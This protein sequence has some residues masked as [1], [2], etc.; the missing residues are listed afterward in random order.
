MLDLSADITFVARSAVYR[1][2][3]SFTS[4]R[5]GGAPPNINHVIHYNVGDQSFTVSIRESQLTPYYQQTF[6]VDDINASES[7]DFET[8]YERDGDR[9]VLSRPDDPDLG[10]KYVAYAGWV[11]D[12]AIPIGTDTVLNNRGFSTFG[13]ETEFE[14]MPNAGQATYVLR[15]VGTLIDANG[16]LN[17]GGDGALTADFASGLIETTMTIETIENGVATAWDTV[18][19]PAI[20]ASGYPSGGSNAFAGYVSRQS[21]PSENFEYSGSF[22]GPNAEEV[23]GVFSYNDFNIN[24]EYLIGSFVGATTA[25]NT[26]RPGLNT[27]LA[28]LTTSEIF[29]AYTSEMGGYSEPVAFVNSS[30][31]SV[32]Y[33]AVTDQFVLPIPIDPFHPN[34]QTRLGV[35]TVGSTDIDTANSD[36]TQTVYEL[37]NLGGLITDNYTLFTPGASPYA[38]S[39]VAIGAWR[40]EDVIATLPFTGPGYSKLTSHV[41]FGQRTAPSDVPT[42][43]SATYN[44]HALGTHYDASAVRDLVGDGTIVAHFNPHTFDVDLNLSFVDSSGAL[45][46]WHVFSASGSPSYASYW[47]GDGNPNL[48]IPIQADDALNLTGTIRGSFFGPLGE[49]I[50]GV[51]TVDDRF[52]TTPSTEAAIGAFVGTKG[53]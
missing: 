8:V 1:E 17:V 33:D 14:Q 18:T 35:V 27:S 25:S 21:L 52:N 19:G 44:I 30:I 46:P 51:F 49:E 10:L 53:P 37:A 6:S 20:I 47:P 11:S 26:P 29:F 38:L 12:D 32:S 34:A 13:F 42:G 16:A 5:I 50:G 28:N 3:G 39:Y 23:G 2:F 31:L 45:T 36:A 15:I 22:F 43:A 9:L 40:N 48:G 41:A 4:A 24:Q 7:T